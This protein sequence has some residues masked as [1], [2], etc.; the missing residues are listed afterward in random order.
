MGAARL[1]YTRMPAPAPGEPALVELAAYGPLA[2]DWVPDVYIGCNRLFKR[3]AA[4]R[5]VSGSNRCRRRTW[6][7][8]RH[9]SCMTERFRLIRIRP[10]ANGQAYPQDNARIAITRSFSWSVHRAASKGVGWLPN[11]MQLMLDGTGLTL[12]PINRFQPCSTS[13]TSSLWPN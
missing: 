4:P 6:R 2:G 7:G 8:I 1:S 13:P 10:F 12:C 11:P 9:Q 3:A 5:A